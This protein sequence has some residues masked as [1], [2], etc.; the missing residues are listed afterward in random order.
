MKNRHRL[1]LLPLV[2]AA[3]LLPPSARAAAPAP[4]PATGEPTVGADYPDARRI[5][6]QRKVPLLVEFYTDW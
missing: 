1:T 5:A 3:L 6:A 2:L 4:P